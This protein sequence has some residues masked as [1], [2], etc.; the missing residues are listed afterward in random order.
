MVVGC[1]FLPILFFA[2][3]HLVMLIG[4]NVPIL[5]AL[6]LDVH[7]YWRLINLLEE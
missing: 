2:L 7:V 6:L 4:L 1:S 5:V 3:L